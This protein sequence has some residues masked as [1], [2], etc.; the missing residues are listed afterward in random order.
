MTDA[1]VSRAHAEVLVRSIP[2]ARVSR[3]SVE[4]LYGVNQYVQMAA[5]VA[6][7]TAA[8]SLDLVALAVDVQLTAEVPRPTASFNL[9]TDP[10]AQLTAEVPRPTADFA[11]SAFTPMSMA[12]TVAAPTF[13]AELD[14]GDLEYVEAV[15]ALGPVGYW[16]MG[17]AVVDGVVGESVADN[18]RDISGND[19][20]GHFLGLPFFGLQS[21][22]RI[23]QGPG[24]V[25]TDEL[26]KSTRYIDQTSWSGTEHPRGEVDHDTWLDLPSFTAIAWYRGNSDAP[27]PIMGRGKFSG[28]NGGSAPEDN[29]ESGPWAMWTEGAGAVLAVVRGRQSPPAPFA[30]WDLYRKVFPG[31]TAQNQDVPHMLVLRY[32]ATT[33]THAFLVDTV[34]I[35]PQ[36]GS[37]NTLTNGMGLGQSVAPLILGSTGGEGGAGNTLDADELALFDYALSDEEIES[38]YYIGYVQQV[39]LAA[40]VQRPTMSATLLPEL[41][42]TMAATVRPPTFAATVVLSP[43][44][45]LA[46]TVARPTTEFSVDVAPAVELAAT[47]DRPTAAFDLAPAPDVQVTATVPPPTADFNIT[48]VREVTVTATVPRPTATFTLALTR[49]VTMAATVEPPVADFTLAPEQYLTMAAT[50][51]RPTAAMLLAF[52]PQTDTSNRV[53]GRTRS[54]IGVAEWDPP[55]VPLPAEL[56][57]G[58]SHIYAQAFSVP[59]IVGAMPRYSVDMKWRHRLLDRIVVGNTDV[60]YFRGVPTPFPGYGLTEPLM[61][62]PTAITFPQIAAAF[63]QPGVGVLRWLD[64]GKPVLL[65]RVDRDTGAVVKEDYVGVVVGFDADGPS[66]VAQVGGEAMGRAALVNRQVPIWTST[67]DIGRYMYSAFKDL[68]LRL[69]PYLGPETGVRLQR[70]GGQSVL[71]YISELVSRSWNRQGNRW[72]VMPDQDATTRGVYKM[73]RKDTT[74]IHATAYVDDARV[75]PSLHR[76]AAEEP[77]RIFGT[78]VTPNGKR[79]RNGVYPGLRQS[80]PAPY[81]MN[82]GSAFG[83]GTTNADTDTGDGITV[84]IQ[85]LIVV[86]YLD[87]E[88]TPGGYDEQVR[89]AIMRLQ[90]DAGRSFVNG[91]MD[92]ETWDALY[93]LNVT[94]FSLRWSHIEPM[95]QDP[96]VRKWNRSGTGAIMGRNPRYQAARLKV[97]RN[98]DFGSGY[99]SN[100]MGEWSA[101]ELGDADQ[102]N[103][104]GSLSI[105]IGAVIRGEHNPGDAWDDSD[106]MDARDLRPGWNIWLP[107][108]DGG[109][110]VHIAAVNVGADG[111]V[112]IDVDTRARDAMEVW[113]VISRNR[114]S[115]NSPARVWR[116]DHRSSTM[117]K[118]SMGIWDEIGGVLGDPVEV[119]ANTWTVFPV[120]AGQEGTVRALLLRTQPFAEYVVGVFGD[121]IYGSRLQRLVGNPLTH[122]GKLRWASEAIRD[123]L[124]NVNLMLYVAGEK[125]DPC[126]YYPNHKRVED[127]PDTPT[128]ETGTNPLTGRWED[129]A[130]FSYYTGRNPVLYVAVYA[131]RATTIPRGRVMENQLEAGV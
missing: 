113:E 12:A 45:S 9:S 122:D 40:E 89:R 80:R 41:I 124:R 111:T 77:N 99:T 2:D 65:Q 37:N 103:W 129:E 19:H 95:A 70:F 131:D 10:F 39:E 125:A 36:L 52:P 91:I 1:Q 63:E 43:G 82:D 109:T 28:S 50:V 31:S 47:V 34:P 61:Y 73:K 90:E 55:V 110:L 57:A 26:N 104:V 97:D 115:R 118:D 94:G 15:L 83:V 96:R 107:L 4:V 23:E 92:E 3:V 78:G 64:V 59:T 24:I 93:D 66:L 100:Q 18:I 76:D 38:L 105:T 123:E 42:A 114:D 75:R 81:P 48:T 21:D 127:D 22:N 16:R 71:D 119:P 25:N 29:D 35:P 85:R 5:T 54:G 44:M 68:G 116:A 13:A 101:A 130:G 49:T 112:S 69:T 27:R 8:F 30:E 102:K 87:Q 88:D 117:T 98:I 32:D 128:E 56:D 67:Q 6:R 86:K 106:V 108:F 46:A 53:G 7:P 14:L 11:V 84:M 33:A 62:G 60:T 58:A 79:V 51:I 74:T 120:V 72:T 20:H 126:G 121:V 17:D